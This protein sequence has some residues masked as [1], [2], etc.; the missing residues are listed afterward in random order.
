MA[1]HIL[2][3]LRNRNTPPHLLYVLSRDLAFFCT[4]S[5][6][7]DRSSDL[8]RS[9]SREVSY[10]PDFSGFL[11]NH[12]FGKTLR[13]GSTHCFCVRASRHSI[14]CP[15]SNF[16]LYLDICRLIKVDISFGF[17]FRSLTRHGAI[18]DEPFIGSAPYNR[19][20][21]YLSDLGIDEGET[22]HSLRSECSITLELIGVPK[23]DIARHGRPLFL[24]KRG[25]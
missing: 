11:L 4:D 25:I 6:A 20:T 3:K 19:L 13:G 24:A 21:G 23:Q 8:G 5:Y 7:G 22:P 9:K 2:S 15:V 12:T 14:L 10:L 16:K 18:S 1:K 17:L